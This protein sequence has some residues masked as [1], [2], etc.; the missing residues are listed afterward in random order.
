MNKILI[1]TGA[2]IGRPNGRDFTLI[3]GI[4]KW[5]KCDG[6]EFMMYSTWQD[7]RERIVDYLIAT[8][9][10][11]PTIHCQKGI[12]E[13]IAEGLTEQAFERFEG[14]IAMAEKIGAKIAV[15]HLWN[16]QISDTH[17]GRTL[18]AVPRL[19]RIAESHGVTVTFENV[20]CAVES[21]LEHLL[22][23]HSLFPDAAF[24]FD[25][26]MA[27]FH[28]ELDRMFGKEGDAL[29]NGPIKHV[30]VNDYRGGYKDWANLKT[31]PIGA[32]NINFKKLF[33]NLREKGYK[34]DYTI[35]ATAFDQTGVVDI[36]MLNDS[37]ERLRAL[38]NG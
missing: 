6:L 20:V 16:G 21:P 25:S 10:D 29:W 38:I 27:A 30:H 5:L 36:D 31:L 35:E 4:R 7:Q 1:T 8:G 26:K 19:I 22:Q 13:D 28:E 3:E 33:E 37:V 34:G 17:M 14:D 9:I 12:G 15:L 18:A 32:G 2:I 11:F 23:I 24:T